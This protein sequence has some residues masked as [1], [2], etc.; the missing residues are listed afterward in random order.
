MHAC[1]C[2]HVCVLGV[3][4]SVHVCFMCVQVHVCTCMCVF[5][6]VSHMKCDGGT[7]LWGRKEGNGK[8]G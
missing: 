2:A 5:A 1:T 4:A 3:C 6:R 8:D 7:A